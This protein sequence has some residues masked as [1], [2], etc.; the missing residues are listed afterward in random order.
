MEEFLSD[1]KEY[2]NEG[3]DEEKEVGCLD[4]TSSDEIEEGAGD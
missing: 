2:K 3:I 4:E 1:R